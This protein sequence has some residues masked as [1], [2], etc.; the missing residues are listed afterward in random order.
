MKTGINWFDQE[1]P[2]LV[3]PAMAKAIGLHEALFVQQLDYWLHRHPHIRNQQKWVYNTYEEWNNQFPFWSIRTIKRIVSGLRK[4]GIIET[5]DRY[6]PIPV[7]RT[8]WY[9][10]CYETLQKRCGISQS[11]NLE[12]SEVAQGGQ[13]VTYEQDSL[14]LWGD[15]NM[16]QCG[17]EQCQPV[18]PKVSTWNPDMG[19]PDPLKRATLSPSSIYTETTTE[20]TTEITTTTTDPLDLARQDPPE[21]V[22]V[23]V[24]HPPEVLQLIEIGLPEAKAVEFFN[25]RGPAYIEEKIDI[26][27]NQAEVRY[28]SRWLL[29]ALEKDFQAENY[30]R[31]DPAEQ[32]RQKLA[33]Q[34]AAE[35]QVYQVQETARLAKAQQAES[36]RFQALHNQYGMSQYH[37]DCWKKGIGY[38]KDFVLQGNSLLTQALEATILLDFS[39]NHARLGVLDEA[40][41][42]Q[43]QQ[44]GKQF[45]QEAIAYAMHDELQAAK[46]TYALE[47]L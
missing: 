23:V 25:T 32:Q 14:P 17:V 46:I 15:D 13:L 47:Q 12:H 44:R 18:T 27:H 16:A 42:F 26:L 29:A 2:L 41:M 22:V 34:M 40:M 19:Q 21:E 6:N 38:C 33:Q 20:T 9:T 45:L 43:L 5:T 39:E 31:P 10:I 8:L 7:D 28:P 24:P 4:D 1:S 37:F 36:Q 11:A 3:Q 35:Q 30:I